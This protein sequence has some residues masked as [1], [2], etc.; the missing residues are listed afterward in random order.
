[1]QPSED[2]LV[3]SVLV[4]DS[5]PEVLKE[6]RRLL[7]QEGFEVAV[8]RSGE[9]ALKMIAHES[10]C[11]VLTDISLPDVGGLEL[12]RAMREN[13]PDTPVILMTAMNDLDTARG[14]LKHGAFH[15]VQK[16]LAA[17]DLVVICRRAAET[18]RL[19]VENEAL[20][21]QALIHDRAA[22]PGL[23][24]SLRPERAAL[25]RAALVRVTHFVGEAISKT[26]T[27]A[28]ERVLGEPAPSVALTD[29][30]AELLL[31]DAAEGEWAAALLHGARVQ[32]DL[33]R[34]AGGGLSA[35]DVGTLL[36][37]GRAAVDKRRR[38]G[39]LLGLRLPNGDVVYPAAQFRK[40]DVVPGL[41]EVLGA[42][43]IHD[44]WMQ[45]DVLLARDEAL[46]GRTGFEALAHRDLQAVKA[47]VSSTGDQGL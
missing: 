28:L 21:R 29:V 17:D 16:P 30:L 27:R 19:K 8:A 2:S 40:G 37:I 22:S 26:S 11:L 23:R 33:L 13:H 15:Y 47:V 3:H 14:A 39:A 36:Q 10:P 7:E 38:H 43:R 20:R 44:P 42:F 6:V 9:T 31:E 4:V 45:L 12:L 24:S 1:M 41:E 5:E 34:E 25:E 35:S 32:R 46:G 18:L